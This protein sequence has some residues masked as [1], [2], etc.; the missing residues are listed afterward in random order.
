MLLEVLV[1]PQDKGLLI[2]PEDK[3]DLVNERS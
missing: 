3:Q 2:Y 1:R